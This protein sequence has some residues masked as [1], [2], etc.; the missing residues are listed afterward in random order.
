[1]YQHYELHG[2][3]KEKKMSFSTFLMF[4]KGL[5]YRQHRWVVSIRHWCQQISR[6]TLINSMVCTI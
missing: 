5:W 1:M 4:E 2:L 6:K 3:F